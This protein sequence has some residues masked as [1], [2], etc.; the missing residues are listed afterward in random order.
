MH[1]QTILKRRLPN[2]IRLPRRAALVALD[3]VPVQKHAVTGYDLARLEDGD[4]AHD[5][6]YTA[7]PP[8][9]PEFFDYAKEVTKNSVTYLDQAQALERALKADRK[10]VATA[11]GG[12]SLPRLRSFLFDPEAK[13][14]RTG[15]SEQFASSF[16]VL[17][18][19]LG[20]PTRVMVG[21]G[22]GSPLAT[23]PKVSVVRGKDALALPEVYFAGFGWV[24]FNPTPDLTAVSP[25]PADTVN[26]Q[27]PPA[28]A[29]VPTQVGQPDAPAPSP[30]S[31]PWL[32][33]L[34]VLGGAVLAV[35]GLLVGRLLRR[36]R[37]HRAGAVGAWWSVLDS[38]RLG[39]TS[40]QPS[41]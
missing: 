17:A 21:F 20:I 8:L 26:R 34:A 40:P 2:R 38:L 3:I 4:V 28:T 35:I 10:F 19:S 7:L 25:P 13:G 41:R 16:A 23:D 18:R 31:R 30:P 33:V 12:S 15:T 37:Q 14:G 11:P 6:R 29:P 27:P 39:G 5:D 9:P 22:A 36:R 1:P 24:P 32:L